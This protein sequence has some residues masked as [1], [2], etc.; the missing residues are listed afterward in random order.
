MMKKITLLVF[1]MSAMQ[2]FAQDNRLF[3]LRFAFKH[4][5]TARAALPVAAVTNT[6][7]I[8]YNPTT[9]EFWLGSSH[10]DT[11]LR[12]SV[13]QGR[14]LGALTTPRLTNGTASRHVRNWTVKENFFI[15]A[16]N[17]TDTVRKLDP[18]TGAEV[19]RFNVPRWIYSNG[20]TNNIAYD[21]TDG[22]GFWI[23]NTSDSMIR[24]IDTSFVRIK[25]S[26][27]II[28]WG[29]GTVE[30][31]AFDG[32]SV[33]GPY[34]LMY[35]PRHPEFPDLKPSYPTNSSASA[36][37]TV[38]Y[39]LTTRARTGV[40]KTI[41]DDFDFTL[42]V[43]QSPRAMTLASIP[44][45]PKRV[46]IMKTGYFSGSS[47]TPSILSGVTAGYDYDYAYRPDGSI[48]SMQVVPNY[49]MIPAAF[50]RPLSI[51]TKT[52]NVVAFQ[53]TQGT[54]ITESFNNNVRTSTQNVPFNL[55][56][57]AFQYSTLATTVPVQRGMN[58]ITSS[59]V[60]TNDPIRRND[61]MSRYV[62][63]SDSTL[64]RDYVD[65]TPNLNIAANRYCFC[66]NAATVFAE[67]P[68][69]GQSYRLDVPATL[70]TITAKVSIGKTGDTTRFNV[71]RLDA[72]RRLSFWGQTALYLIQPSD[73]ATNTLTLPLTRP[74]DIPAN[75]EFLVTITE[76]FNNASI[77]GT[78]LGYERGSVF[79][80][81]IQRFGGWIQVDTSTSG[82]VTN[83]KGKALA[84]RPNFKIRTNTNEVSAFE[85]LTIAPNPT[86][87]LVSLDL[88]TVKE[89]DVSVRVYN[90]NGQVMM[91]RKY[92]N[93]KNMTENLDFS[94][95]ANG[96]YIVS[97]TTNQGTVNRKVV[98]E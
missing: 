3:P 41:M 2:M 85:N 10:N 18:R 82:F 62:F 13:P 35:M 53:N 44:S 11:I 69:I 17:N 70:T 30:S 37:T 4:S 43:N 67:K 75:Q 97:L 34:L 25:D 94:D 56:A 48:D 90:I 66:A 22:G 64:A 96:V 95:F 50:G 68:E 39:S 93:V 80:H 73:S 12:F 31:L 16:A 92:D 78:S 6:K 57:Q 98:K 15:Y 26:I 81:G 20:A 84:I 60:V 49:S 7:A 87:G 59:L 29:A 76:G 83:V 65:Y 23:S 14:Y 52:R 32:T 61:T 27:K 51:T 9:N 45:L 8:V 58:T 5:D 28:G 55:A 1:L 88:T 19:A 79:M 91:N 63:L 42:N 74:I 72:N 46:L 71:Y 47:L 86:T 89:G 54:I 40:Y 24:K 36:A 21:S 38:Q 77:I 33:G